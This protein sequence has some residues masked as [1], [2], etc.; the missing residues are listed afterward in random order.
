MQVTLPAEV[1]IN[2]AF[3]PA[4]LKKL[5]QFANEISNTLRNV[6]KLC[7][8]EL[9][10]SKLACT[11]HPTGINLFFFIRLCSSIK[12][13]SRALLDWR[14]FPSNLVEIFFLAF[15]WKNGL[16]LLNLQ[17]CIGVL[18]NDYYY[19]ILYEWALLM[20]MNESLILFSWN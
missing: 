5:N 18:T 10:S 11:I 1:P 3:K 9:C 17:L 2:N 20:S 7:P 6:C 12:L 4:V 19:A 8:L 16:H 15:L 13:S 14:V